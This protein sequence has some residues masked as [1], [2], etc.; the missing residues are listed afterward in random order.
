MSGSG[1]E[2]SEPGIGGVG[3]LAQ[4]WARILAVASVALLVVLLWTLVLRADGGSW[5]EAEAIAVP[6]GVLFAAVAVAARFPVRAL[7]AR[8]TPWSR[9]IAVHGMGAV[10]VA[11]IWGLLG[12]GW[13][14]F[15]ERAGFFPGAVER[16][17]GRLGPILG[18]A[19]VG[20]LLAVSVHALLAAAEEAREAQQRALSAVAAAREAELKALRSQLGPHFLFNS[21]NTVSSLIG[22]EPEAARR[23]CA[24][25][26][27]VLRRTLRTPSLERVSLAEELNLARDLLAIE[28]LRFGSRLRVR[29][30]TSG[31]DPE[32]MA[33]PPFVLLPLVENAITHGI[34]ER[35]DGGA[36]D[37]SVGRDGDRARLEV[38]ND[39]DPERRRRGG[40]GLGLDLAR[41]RLHTAYGPL[42]ALETFDEG[43]RYRVVLRWPIEPALAKGEVG[44]V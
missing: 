44:V 42:A 36:V 14:M 32:Q 26:G 12:R 31:V 6:L 30:E 11:A 7:P 17:D 4:D 34:A 35:I 38:G 40:T 10:T 3:S 22:R 24:L 29:T 41:R 21:L 16:V 9:L 19:T 1:G 2:R 27:S 43:A 18:F 15:L 28:V 37:I 39:C 5:A 20:Y 25:L 33:V 13:A 23:A 8:R